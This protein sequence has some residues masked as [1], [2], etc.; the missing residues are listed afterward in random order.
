[1]FIDI[2]VGSIATSLEAAAV[3]GE[4]EDGG[5]G[6]FVCSN[7]WVKEEKYKVHK[8]RMREA[9]GLEKQVRA[10]ARVYLNQNHC[11]MP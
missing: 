5:G 1:M 11:P 2:Q 10:R 4:M 7:S 9:E 6:V 8:V 3:V